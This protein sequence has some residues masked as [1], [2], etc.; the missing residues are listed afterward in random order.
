METGER[1]LLE[2][3]GIYMLLVTLWRVPTLCLL[4]RPI[5]YKQEV[6]QYL[7]RTFQIAE[8]ELSWREC[9]IAEYKNSR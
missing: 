7:G 9:K 5:R 3:E 1:R 2:Y 4:Q 8:S 6:S